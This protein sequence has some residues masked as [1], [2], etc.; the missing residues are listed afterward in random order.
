[1]IVL[2]PLDPNAAMTV[3]SAMITPAVLISACGSLAISTSNRL[4]RTIDRTRKLSETFSELARE[5]QKEGLAER[6]ALLFDLL[7]RSTQR[8][9]L[10]VR[11][12]LRIYLAIT[13]FVATSV[14][15]GIV[16]FTDAAYAWIPIA[17]GITGAGLLFHASILLMTESRIALGAIRNEM[18]FVWQVRQQTAPPGLLEPERDLQARIWLP[19]LTRVKEK[20]GNE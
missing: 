8:S 7:G 9:R 5:E 14:A 2:I 3:L 19:W 18:D 10:L 4:G 6:Q 15:I 12:M 16:V 11:A 13:L 1:L 17:L 20:H